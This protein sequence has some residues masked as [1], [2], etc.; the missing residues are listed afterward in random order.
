MALP[1]TA[2]GTWKVGALLEPPPQ[3]LSTM[4]KIAAQAL[5]VRRSAICMVPSPVAIIFLWPITGTSPDRMMVYT[6]IR[7][8]S[9]H[10]AIVPDSNHGSQPH[11]RA[12]RFTVRQVP[13]SVFF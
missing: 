7:V 13:F 12:Q 4:G 3:A 9:K 5:A 8:P 1:A 2:V 6:I 11:R 10:E